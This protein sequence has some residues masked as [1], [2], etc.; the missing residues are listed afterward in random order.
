[1][2]R[3]AK[4]DGRVADL[5]FVGLG[6]M[7]GAMAG[8]LV[9]AGFALTVHDLSA[10]AAADVVNSGAE[11]VASARAVAAVSDHVGVCVPADEHVIDVVTGDQGLLAGARPGLSVAVH[12][13]VRPGTVVDLA[14]TAA[15]QG[16]VL[17]DA[18]VAGGGERA[19]RGELAITVGVPEGGLP[20]VARAALEACGGLVVECGPVGTG[21]ATKIA[22]NVMTYLQFAGIS[23]AFDVVRTGGGD[24]AVV[25]EV[26]RHNE[27]LGDLTE[28]FS[29]VP[30]MATEDK[31]AAGFADYLWTTIALAEKDLDLAAQLS[32]DD[33]GPRPILDAVRDSMWRV[34]GM[35]APGPPA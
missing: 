19:R 7:G 26:L 33:A 18:G 23:A 11:S 17:F 12:S 14:A 24:P 34:Y 10:E 31:T 21:L 27:M 15:E 6:D 1:M 35:G 8:C 30:L 32:P 3:R 16:V 25:L 22:V 2:P 9:D 28:Q 29:A 20:D 4:A 13:T 5:G